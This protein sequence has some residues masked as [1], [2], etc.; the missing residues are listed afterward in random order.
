LPKR[1]LN[2]LPKG[3][4]SRR[5]RDPQELLQEQIEVLQGRVGTLETRKAP[6]EPSPSLSEPIVYNGRDGVDGEQGPQGPQ[7]ESGVGFRWR[8]LWKE[9]ESYEANDVVGYNGSSY[10]ANRPSQRSYPNRVNNEWDL[11][12]AA[13]A[14]GAN[15]RNVVDAGGVDSLLWGDYA[16]NFASDPVQVGTVAEGDVYQ[17]DYDNGTAYRLVPTDGMSQDGFYSTFSGGVLSGLIVERGMS[18]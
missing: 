16:L 12:V 3:G 8:G 17:Y 5:L 15:G 10:I 14:P 4:F 11:M 7:G 2:A 18:I 13:G 9:S 6:P 1:T